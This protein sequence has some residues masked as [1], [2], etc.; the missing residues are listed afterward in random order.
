MSTESEREEEMIVSGTDV[1]SKVEITP[2]ILSHMLINRRILV[3]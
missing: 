1:L 3:F 2:L